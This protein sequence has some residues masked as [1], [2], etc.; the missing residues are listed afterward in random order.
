[1]ITDSKFAVLDLVR[2]RRPSVVAIDGCDGSGKS[3]L[4]RYLA[5]QLERPLFE[6][7]TYLDK[8]LGL[9]VSAIKFDDLKRD[10]GKFS[11]MIIE[12]VCLMEVLR[13]LDITPDLTIYVKRMHLGVWAE[14]DD[15]TLEPDEIDIKLANVKESIR[16][17][18]DIGKPPGAP[19]PRLSEI[20]LGLEEELIRYHAKYRPQNSSDIIFQRNDS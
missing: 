14:E 11:D 13:R 19:E 8:N 15:Y 1:M 2:V 9:Y 17:M 6:L 10:I 4:A 20:E 18:E 12:G 16:M 5:T 7:D 3:T